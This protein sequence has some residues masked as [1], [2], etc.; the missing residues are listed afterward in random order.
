MFVSYLT[1]SKH[2]IEAMVMDTNTDMVTDM[3]MVTAMAMAMEVDTMK[4]KNQ[5]NFLLNGSIE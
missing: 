2:R 4:K 5:K 1:P 3:V